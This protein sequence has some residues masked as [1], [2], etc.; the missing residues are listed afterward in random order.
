MS[1][2]AQN[3]S[4]HCYKCSQKYFSGSSGP[5]PTMIPKDKNYHRTMGSPL[6]SFT[7]LAVVNKHCKCEGMKNVEHNTDIQHI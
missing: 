5:N 1:V 2:N 6:I 7:G 3:R 4:K